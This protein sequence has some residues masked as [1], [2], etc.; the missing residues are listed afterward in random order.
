MLAAESARA[1]ALLYAGETDAA[2]QALMTILEKK[3]DYAP[4][5][6]G[7]ARCEYVRDEP[8]SLE[9]AWKLVQHAL[10]LDSDRIEAHCLAAWVARARD[11]SEA[12]R[13]FTESAAALQPHHSEVKLLRAELGLARANLAEM[14]RF[15][16]EVLQQTDDARA[17]AAAYR[18]L[19][20]AYDA[21]GQIEAAA[22]ARRAR[23]EH[24]RAAMHPLSMLSAQ[25][26]E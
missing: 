15:A 20:I 16:T 23:A 25:R 3:R 10:E 12:A 1:E 11:D 2:R 5:Y 24:L 7:L 19:I 9:R 6:V 21:G 22:E 14:V 13:R 8:E 26:V 17:R 18:Y 4:A